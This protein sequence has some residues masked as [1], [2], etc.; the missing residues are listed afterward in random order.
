MVD[1]VHSYVE[2]LCVDL[3]VLW[4][5]EVLLGDENTLTEEVLVDLLA[6]GLGDEPKKLI[7]PCQR[8]SVIFLSSH[9]AGSC[10]KMLA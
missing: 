10:R 4:L 1:I 5:V 7:S 3:A 6:I 8:N 2:V 9:L